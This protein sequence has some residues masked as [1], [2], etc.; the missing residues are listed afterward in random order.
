[1]GAGLRLAFVF[2]T[3]RGVTPFEFPVVAGVGARL[4]FGMTA[5]AF[6]FRFVALAFAFPF[7]LLF[8]RGEGFFLGVGLGLA[9]A[10]VVLAF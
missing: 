5:F 6:R 10:D 9:L 3:G 2:R 8:A 1:M 4:A 7:A